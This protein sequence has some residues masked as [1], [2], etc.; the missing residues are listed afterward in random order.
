[1]VQRIKKGD[2]VAVITGK[3]RGKQG[4]VLEVNHAADT[5]RVRGIAMQT[6]HL[7][8]RKANTPGKIEQLEAFIQASNVMPVCP[9]TGKP[10]RVRSNVVDGKRVRVSHRSGVTI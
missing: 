2:L 6:K 9:Q 7:K 8:P 10:C 4:R 5:V 1:M 3:D